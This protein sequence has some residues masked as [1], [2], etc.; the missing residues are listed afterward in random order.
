MSSTRKKKAKTQLATIEKHARP[1]RSK[2]LGK[3]AAAALT[4]TH[5]EIITPRDMP[6]ESSIDVPASLFGAFKQKQKKGR[7]RQ[8]L[9]QRRDDGGVKHQTQGCAT[10]P[11]P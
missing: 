4:Q 10:P 9:E 7:A 8:R 2:D 6:R 1:T 11:P 5:M 3:H